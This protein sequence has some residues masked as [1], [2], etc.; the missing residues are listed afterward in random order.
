[1]EGSP[2]GLSIAL[3]LMVL[4]LLAIRSVSAALEAALVA[5]GLPRAQA[6]ASAAGAPRAARALESLLSDPEGTALTLRLAGTWTVLFAGLLAGWL[7]ARL[8][9]AH[10]LLGGAGTALAAGLLAVPLAAALRGLGASRGEPVALALAPAFRSLRAVIRPLGRPAAL[11]AGR[12]GR[13]SLPRPPLDEMERALAE[14]ARGQGAG[15]EATSELIHAVFEFREK[16]ARDVM[17]PRTDVV[18][19]DIDTPVEEIIRILAEEGHSRMPVYRE[20]L[21]HIVGVL[22][23]RDLVPLL[24]H[25]ELILLRDLLR[26]AHFVPWSKPVE[27]LLRE[28]QRRKLHMSFVVDEHG[29]VMGLCTIEDVLEEIVGEIRDEFEEEESGRE[30]EAH[31]DGT[32]TVLGDVAIAELNRATGAGV[33]EDDGYETVAGFLNSIAGAIPSKGDRLFWRGWAF[34]VVD[35]GPRRVTKVRASRVKRA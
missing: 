14:Y 29:G 32:F 13:F 17:V 28:M 2:N 16:V 3:A 6:L 1:M 9:P 7:G 34:T 11:L 30:V 33:P 26:P 20:D 18:A 5:V 4:G 12:W 19:V 22:H 8:A 35:A 24:A 10:P 15:A 25:P 27:H 31:A 21:D 23:A